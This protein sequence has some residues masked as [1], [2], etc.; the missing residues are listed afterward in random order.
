M[1]KYPCIFKTAF[2]KEQV[3]PRLWREHPKTP[4]GAFTRQFRSIHCSIVNP[5]GEDC[6]YSPED[7]AIAFYVSAEQTMRQAKSSPV[8]LFKM[9]TKTKAL[10]RVEKKP[11]ARERYDRTDGQQ[12]G[13]GGLRIGPRPGPMDVLEVPD[14]SDRARR[15]AGQQP[16]GLRGDSHR[17]QSLGDMLR[18]DGEGSRTQPY[19][20][21][22][23]EAGSD[24]DGEPRD[25]VPPPSPRRLGDQPPSGDPDLHQGGE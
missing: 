24:R 18:G 7:C 10:D 19:R 2:L 5:Y 8:G 14:G 4:I 12:E 1:A 21:H 23:G 3:L 9:I 17:P 25:P 11:L 22:E 16:V 20:R 15:V 13:P 6:P